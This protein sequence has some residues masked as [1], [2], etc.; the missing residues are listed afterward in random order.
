MRD[1]GS[2]H[3]DDEQRSDR[4]RHEHRPGAHLVGD[5]EVIGEQDEPGPRRHDDERDG[6]QADRHRKRRFA[7]RGQFGRDAQVAGH[8]RDH[9]CDVPAKHVAQPDL[10]RLQIATAHHAQ[11][12]VAHDAQTEN[13]QLEHNAAESHALQPLLQQ[14]EGP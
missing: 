2:G 6:R 3:E 12:H 11:K 5:I 1:G 10:A 7:R 13:I 8:K 4:V 14:L 9:G